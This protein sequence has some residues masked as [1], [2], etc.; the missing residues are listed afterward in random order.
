MVFRDDIEPVASTGY[1]GSSRWLLL[2]GTLRDAQAGG[3]EVLPM[4]NLWYLVWVAAK[5]DTRSPLYI[6]TKKVAEH[7]RS[8]AQQ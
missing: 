2:R 1:R 7:V 8:D 3:F 5:V 6:V 4:R